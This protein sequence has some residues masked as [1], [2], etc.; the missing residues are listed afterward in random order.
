MKQR[1]PHNI[2][3]S[4]RLGDPQHALRRG[5]SAH[6]FYCSLEEEQRLH[7]LTF[8]G[9][10][11][12]RQ[13][14]HTKRIPILRDLEDTLEHWRSVDQYLVSREVGDGILVIGYFFGRHL[15]QIWDESVEILGRHADTPTLVDLRT[16]ADALCDKYSPEWVSLFLAAA[17]EVK[18]RAKPQLI[19]FNDVSHPAC[20]FLIPE[21]PVARE[22]AVRENEVDPVTRERRQVRR[23]IERV[24]RKELRE[25]R[26]AATALS[27]ELEKGTRGREVVIDSN[28]TGVD[29]VAPTA[30]IEI[31][32]LQHPRLPGAVTNLEAEPVGRIGSA[33]VRWG[34][35]PE[36][37]KARPVVVIGSNTRYLWVRPIFSKDF[38]AGLWRSVVIH[39]WKS[40]GLDHA[41]YVSID[42][43]RVRRD[44][45]VI[46]NGSLSTHDWNRVCRG[47]VHD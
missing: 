2:R 40:A 10:D 45:C 7:L 33:F 13:V 9:L 11:Y 1:K 44:R 4:R 23:K 14:G 16:M 37:G 42:V 27:R 5:G 34:P 41:S 15:N 21:V 36:Q 18:L 17:V 24:K 30:N 38:K 32:R 31:H 22:V 12:I 29:A 26:E 3:P 8:L 43:I 46:G 19:E 20:P 28:D 47:E 35:L 25:Q 6:R 39:D